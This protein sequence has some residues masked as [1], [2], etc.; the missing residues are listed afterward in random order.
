VTDQIKN[1]VVG[2]IVVFALAIIFIPKI[3]DGKKES[4]KREFVTI[5]QKPAHQIPKNYTMPKTEEVSIVHLNNEEG[6]VIDSEN[7]EESNQ[8]ESPTESMSEKG[9]VVASKAEAWVI[10]MGSFG[11]PDNVNAFVKKLREKGFTAFSVPAVPKLGISNKVF[12]GPE[13]NHGVLVK[14]QPK[15][16]NEFKESGV[17]VKYNPLL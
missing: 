12:V 1:R 9:D 14:L 5:P 7:I 11:N 16:K 4:K 8:V 3:Y 2:A 10:R 6:A 15:L 17:I 13:L